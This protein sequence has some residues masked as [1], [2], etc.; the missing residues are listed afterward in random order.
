MSD[1]FDKEAE[2]EKL[3]RTNENANTPSGSPSY[4]CRAPR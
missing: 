1:E 4:S 2:R 3:R